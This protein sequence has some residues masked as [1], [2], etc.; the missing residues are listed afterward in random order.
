MAHHAGDWDGE[1]DLDPELPEA[2]TEVSGGSFVFLAGPEAV[3][4]RLDAYLAGRD[5]LGLSRSQV[6]R[7]IEE[8][9][10]A[11][12]LASARPDPATGLPA[13]VPQR[14]S[15]R[16]QEGDEVHV[17]VPEPE[18]LEVPPEDIALAIIY[19]DSDVLVVNKP[20]GMV[21][22][23]APGNYSGTLVNALLHHCRDLSGIN[24][25]L[26]PGIVHRLDKETTG[27]LMVAKNDQAHQSLAHQIKERTV[28]REYL[29]VAHG[30]FASPSGTVDAPIGRHP[31]DRQRMAV[32]PRHGKH[33]V[34]HFWV[35]A[36]YRD[37]SHGPFSLVACRLET[38]RTHQIR[39]HLAY[40]GHPV[41]CDTVYGP[42]HP[43]FPVAG[44]LLHA[45]VLGFTH[46]R[47][48]QWLEFEAAPPTD[49]QDVLDRL[50]PYRV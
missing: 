8:G 37:P 42:R 31:V 25:V 26:R 49:M 43:A 36:A 7:L 24:G 2:P 15:Y 11:V 16:L 6:Q 20:R 18:P 21:V 32:E 4:Q 35:R 34:T 27:L 23:P 38:G 39:V 33:A 46:P 17:R 5:D 1:L 28:R 48:G 10:V 41:A 3:G 13:A 30:H 29:A 44:Q 22:H 19:E 40:I 45:R 47:T 12:T 14:S 9:L 50:Q